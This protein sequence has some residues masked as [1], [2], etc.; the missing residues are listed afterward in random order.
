MPIL[1]RL[2]SVQKQGIQWT[3]KSACSHIFYRIWTKKTKKR[4][5]NWSYN[6]DLCMAVKKI[7]SALFS[8]LIVPFVCFWRIHIYFRRIELYILLH[9]FCFINYF[10]R[11]SWKQIHAFLHLIWCEMDM[12]FGYTQFV[13]FV[14]VTNVNFILRSE[15][16]MQYFIVVTCQRVH[17]QFL[18]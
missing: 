18:P 5:N 17:T 15:G 11:M 13:M 4:I 2:A 3:T 16:K 8:L 7:L 9:Y 10:L 1:F 14:A 6:M 12:V